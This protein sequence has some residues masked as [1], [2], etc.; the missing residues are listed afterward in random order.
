MEVYGNAGSKPVCG[1]VRSARAR[2]LFVFVFLFLIAAFSAV[3]AQT[4]LKYQE[5]PKA[6][7]DLVDARLTPY[8]VIRIVG[9]DHCGQS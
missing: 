7:I 9:E 6:M 2:R 4:S 5:P 1:S 8:H 3:E